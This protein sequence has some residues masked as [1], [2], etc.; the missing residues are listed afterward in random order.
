[1]RG[2]QPDLAIVDAAKK[3]LGPV[4][5]ILDKHLA[6]STYMAGTDFTLADIGYMPYVEY[7]FASGE[8]ELVTAHKHVA[9]WWNRVSE[10]PSWKKATGKA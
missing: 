4:F 10:R 9:A 2:G 5:D 7:L 8:G 1:M 3:E 6:T